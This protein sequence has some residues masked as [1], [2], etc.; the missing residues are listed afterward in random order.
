MSARGVCSTDRQGSRSRV[1]EVSRTAS[2][3]L[4]LQPEEKTYITYAMLAKKGKPRTIYLFPSLLF[5]LC[6]KGSQLVKN[7]YSYTEGTLEGT[8]PLK[9]PLQSS[10][11][12]LGVV[13]GG[14]GWYSENGV[15]FGD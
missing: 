8:Y 1:E 7:V 10:H 13:F 5:V 12:R 2:T 15:V 4:P 9:C 6:K 11:W 3:R 14:L